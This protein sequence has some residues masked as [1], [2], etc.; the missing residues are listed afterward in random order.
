MAVVIAPVRTEDRGTYTCTARN[1]VGVV[2]ASAQLV[3]AA[4]SSVVLV[5]LQEV[6]NVAMQGEEPCHLTNQ[7]EFKVIRGVGS[8]QEVDLYYTVDS[9]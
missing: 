7:E 9:L 2:S 3:V 8:F 4:M 6:S 5:E 1:V